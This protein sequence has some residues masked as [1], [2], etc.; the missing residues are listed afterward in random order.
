MA[1]DIVLI[2]STSKCNCCHNVVATF[3][4]CCWTGWRFSKKF[5]N[6]ARNCIMH[7]QFNSDIGNLQLVTIFHNNMFYVA[8]TLCQRHIPMNLWI[9][10]SSLKHPKWMKKHILCSRGAKFLFHVQQIV[11]SQNVVTTCQQPYFT[12]SQ[13]L[14]FRQRCHNIAM[15]AGMLPIRIS[16][17]I[18]IIVNFLNW[19]MPLVS[20]KSIHP[21][22]RLCSYLLRRKVTVISGSKF[23]HG[24]TSVISFISEKTPFITQ[25]LCDVLVL[26]LYLYHC[27]VVKKR[28]TTR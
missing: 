3:W 11:L 19:K 15:L 4:S 25:F 24:R 22:Q 6:D 21:N 17:Y 12:T 27:G 8:P 16:K 5:S 9:G 23:H 7:C 1:I 18:D 10:F 2:L 14:T 26:T 28:A 20:S 13:H